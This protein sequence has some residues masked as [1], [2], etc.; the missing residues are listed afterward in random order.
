MPDQEELNDVTCLT[1]REGLRFER[2]FR[3][4]DIAPITASWHLYRI[5]E[6]TTVCAIMCRRKRKSRL[7]VINL[8]ISYNNQLEL[9]VLSERACA[10]L[11]LSDNYHR[12]VLKLRVPFDKPPRRAVIAVL[13]AYV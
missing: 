1:A 12:A 9:A 3:E 5:M 11:P 4:Q 7:F 2:Q 6:A 13:I 10:P 8:Y